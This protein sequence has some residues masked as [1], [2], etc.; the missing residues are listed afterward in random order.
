MA[1][2]RTPRLPEQQLAQ[3]VDKLEADLNEL[4]SGVPQQV[5]SSVVFFQSDTG[6]AYDWT[7]IL[8]QEVGAP[9]GQGLAV[10]SVQAQ[11]T[12]MNN[13]Y[14]NLGDKIFVGSPTSW[15]RPGNYLTDVIAGVPGFQTFYS[16]VPNNT[17]LPSTKVWILSLLGDTTR[18][19]YIKFYVSALDRASITITRL[20]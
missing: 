14:A 2:A 13:L 16:D 7:G 10:F 3:L 5:Q 18:T 8:P 6:A 17:G 20:I 19:A 4:K 1:A 11:A 9:T 12:A 15:Y